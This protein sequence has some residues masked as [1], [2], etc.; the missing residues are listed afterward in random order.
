MRRTIAIFLTLLLCGCDPI[1]GVRR[2]A[3]LDEMPTLECVHQAIA[4]TPGIAQV[5]YRQDTGGRP[6]TLSGIQAPDQTSSFTYVGGQGSHIWGTLQLTRNYRGE[7]AFQQTQLSMGEP[8]PQE[9]IDA[10]RPLM[11]LIE[12]KLESECGLVQLKTDVSESCIGVKCAE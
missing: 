6:L 2:S 11:Q 9:D 1:Y 7:V 3:S 12:R 4:S 8:P 10:T 5:R